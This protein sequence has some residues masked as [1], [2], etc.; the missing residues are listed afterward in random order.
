MGDTAT[1]SLAFEYI[2]AGN[3]GLDAGDQTT[4]PIG[5][6]KLSINSCMGL[7]CLKWGADGE[8]SAVDRQF[9]LQRLALEDNFG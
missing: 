7:T 1:S 3:R 8:L 2:S 9:V 5:D 4:S 6:S